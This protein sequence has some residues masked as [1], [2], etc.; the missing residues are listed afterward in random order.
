[1]AEPLYGALEAGGTKFICAVG[2]GPHDLRSEL[3]LPT[4]DPAATLAAVHRFFDAA[5]ARHGAIAGFGVAAFGPVDLNPSSATWGS[6]TST[7]K[8]GWSHTDI[9]QRLKHAYGRPVAFDTDVN[10][11]A[12]G[13]A[14]WGAG[15]DVESLAYVT[16]G[17]G[18]GGGLSIRGRPLHGLMHPEMGH[19]RVSR[20]PADRY[21]GCCPFH[22]DCLEGLASGPAIVGR[23]GS[24]L[25]LLPECHEAWEME[26]F[27]IGQLL[28]V[29]TAV[30]SPHRIVLGGGAGGLPAIR[31]RSIRA[32]RSSL[33]GY[34]SVESLASKLEEYV[35]GPGLGGRSGLLGALRMAQ[36]AAGDRD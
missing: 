35:V 25:S 17:T 1:M 5:Q 20:H 16:V 32:L 8:A 33:A 11:A 10:G 31:S 27:Y 26:A 18:V 22:G 28:H 34:P 12:L 36:L 29:I 3:T 9:A 21:G 4:L 2:A 19:I 24:I 6:I 7:P 15:Q 30:A 14:H 23:W 13:E